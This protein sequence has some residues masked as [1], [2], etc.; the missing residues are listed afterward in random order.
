MHYDISSIIY[1]AHCQKSVVN[2]CRITVSIIRSTCIQIT[3]C[4]VLKF[5]TTLLC[6]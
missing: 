1:F 6:V 5:L 4:P 2:H 3:K